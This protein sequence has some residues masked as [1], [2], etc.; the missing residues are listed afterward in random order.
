MIALPRLGNSD[1]VIVS[2]DISKVFDM[3]WHTGLLYK[4]KSDDTTLY[5]N[6]GQASNDYSHA[7]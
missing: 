6:C 2:L 4:L 3:V 7:D 5:S 1:H